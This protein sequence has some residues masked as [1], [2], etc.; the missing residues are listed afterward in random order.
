MNPL[1][2]KFNKIGNPDRIKKPEKSLKQLKLRNKYNILKAKKCRQQIKVELADEIV[3]LPKRF[4]EELTEDEI[5]ELSKCSFE[6]LAPMGNSFKINIDLKEHQNEKTDIINRETFEVL[7]EEKAEMNLNQRKILFNIKPVPD[8]FEPI[9]WIKDAINGPFQLAMKDLNS[10]DNVKIIF[11][12]HCYPE[13]Q[14]EEDDEIELFNIHDLEEGDA[15]EKIMKIVQKNWN[16]MT[17][18]KFYIIV[19]IVSLDL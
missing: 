19:T 14:A 18:E 13:H 2:K 1:L 10:S 11:R 4:N 9:S 8:N 7:L 3:Y 6:L 16:N 5:N 17:I 15:W 12:R